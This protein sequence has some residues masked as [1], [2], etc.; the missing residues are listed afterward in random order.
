[1]R[2]IRIA[3][4]IVGVLLLS[5]GGCSGNKVIKVTSTSQELAIRHAPEQRQAADRLAVASCGE[6]DRRARLRYRHDQPLT[7]DQFGLYDCVPR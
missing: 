7:M 5:L 6:Y 4:V 1:M 2:Q 3:A